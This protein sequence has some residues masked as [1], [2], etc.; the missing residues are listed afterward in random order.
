MHPILPRVIPFA[1]FVGLLALNPLLEPLATGLGLHR[2]WTYAIRVG[3]T[4]ALLAGF[5]SSYCELR[6]LRGIGVGDWLLTIAIG[7]IVFVL[8]IHLDFGPFLLAGAAGYD[9]RSPQ[10]AIDWGLATTRL[11]GAVAVVPAM[12]EL[13][14]RSFLLRWVKNANFLA[15]VPADA[16]IKALAVSALLFGLEHH[17]WAAGVLAGVAYGWLYMRSAN[18]WTPVIAHS[19]T[20][21]AL[22]L[23]VLSTGSWQLW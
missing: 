23:W 18:L 8:W 3:A 16:G 15:V 22:G 13:F 12:E 9:P 5:W 6:S 19:I 17:Q 10:G 11:L 7:A 4:A 14:W 1:V 20:N 2:G 21:A